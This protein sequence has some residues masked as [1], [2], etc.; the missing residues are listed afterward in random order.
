[1]GYQESF[2]TTTNKK[3]FN[4]FLD[5]IKKLGWVFYDAHL[6]YPTYIVNVKENVYGEFTKKRIMLKKNKKY[7]Y[8]TGDRHLQRSANNILDVPDDDETILNLDIVFSEEVD[9][10]KIFD[11]NKKDDSAIYAGLSNKWVDVEKFVF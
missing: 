8:F 3:Y 7:V 2:V 11:T 5:R 10:A 9:C 4:D 1:M 6:T